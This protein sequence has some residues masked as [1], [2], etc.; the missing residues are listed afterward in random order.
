I[1]QSMRESA[2]SGLDAES[3][4][5]NSALPPI[6]C[7]MREDWHQG[8]VGIVAG[9]LKER[10]HRPVIAF[11][12]ADNG[13]LKGSGRS[14]ANVHMRDLIDAVDVATDRA[15]IKRF[16]GHA[17]AAGLTLPQQAYEP[18]KAC[19][20][21]IVRE[22]YGDEIVADRIL[23]DGE[24]TADDFTLQRASQLRAAGPWGSGCPAPCFRGEFFVHSTRVV[25]KTH[26]RLELS[27]ANASNQRFEGIAFN[28]IDALPRL[29]K[30]RTDGQQTA[31][32]FRLDVNRY[33]GRDRLQL[34]VD[35]FLPEASL[36]RQ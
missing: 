21:R 14:T 31:I 15:L 17:M 30:N 26:L 6:L 25:G 23:T 2:V 28:A 24:L 33:Q 18:F 7:V 29:T 36:S 32:I 4:E 5:G 34:V 1:E 35:H 12:P 20:E 3:I 11:A 13:E 8:V 9:R 27:P 19:I 16:G 22:K 10:F